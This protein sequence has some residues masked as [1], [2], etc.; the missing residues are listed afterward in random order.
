[1]QS[2]SP[3]RKVKPNN[4]THLLN[5]SSKFTG[6]GGNCSSL[7][8]K[9]V[10]PIPKVKK[11]GIFE[12]KAIEAVEINL[13]KKY[14]DR[15]DLPIA[16]NFHGAHRKI[17]WKLEPE[18]LDYHLYLPIFFEGLRETEEPYKFLADQGCEELLARGGAK[19]F[20]VLPQ[21]II[22]IKKALSTKSHPI[23]CTTLKK[24]QKLVTSSDMIGEALVP[25][26]RQI[27]PVMNMFKNKRL[28]IGD[29]I[30]YSQRKNENLSDLIQETLEILEKYGGEDAYINIKY[31]IPT[32]ES[33]MF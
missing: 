32:Y 30:D 8:P 2:L 23:M 9:K 16:V 28:N 11:T 21:L 20:A 25:Y 24:I 15:G 22:P 4:T 1:M 7:A 5:I 18:L 12:A 19:I 26:Y 14:Y 13:F 17:S 3:S 29:H 10:Q 6:T 33:C 27:L 31:M